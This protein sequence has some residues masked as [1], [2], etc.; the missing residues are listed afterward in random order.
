MDTS[1]QRVNIGWL[2][3]QLINNHGGSA[4]FPM[5][6][7]RHLIRWQRLFPVEDSPLITLPVY[8]VYPLDRQ[9]PHIVTAI[10]GLR[11]LGAEEDLRQSRDDLA[12][13]A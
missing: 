1:A 12:P 5:R 8:M 9:E 11:E 2:A 4:Y 3:M 6:L 7:V 13:L 10:T